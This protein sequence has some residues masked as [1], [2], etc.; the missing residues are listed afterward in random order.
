MI[1]FIMNIASF[2]W[3]VVLY[4]IQNEI[5]I[6]SDCVNG[7]YLSSIIYILTSF[8]LSYLSLLVLKI[9][10]TKIDDDLIIEKIYPVY[11]EYMPVYLAICVVAFELNSYV[12]VENSFTVLLISAFVFILFYISNISYLNPLWYLLG[13]RIYKIENEEGNYIVMMNKTEHSKNIKIIKNI[14]KIDEY[15]FIKKEE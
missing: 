3:I 15:H 8:S 2:S 10:N 6:I 13:K 12:E 5:F 14:V 11:S 4:L 1:K 7:R 9:L